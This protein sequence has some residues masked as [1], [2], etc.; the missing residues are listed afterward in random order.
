MRIPSAQELEPLARKHGLTLIVLFGSQASG[1]THPGS[2]V[3]VA[4]MPSHR[5]SLHEHGE[6][7]AALCDLFEAEVDLGLLD[8]AL[9]LFMVHVAEG[10]A[11]YE[12]EPWTWANFKLY[13]RRL[14]WDT[15]PLRQSLSRYLDRRV[16]DMRHAG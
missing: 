11:L 6:V 9:P 5:L 16:E 10:Q 7:W 2:D 1:R 4:V 3:D 14:Y 12:S 8:H 15:A 13:A